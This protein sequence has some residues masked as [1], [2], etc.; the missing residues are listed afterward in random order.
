M[1]DVGRRARP[2][3]W[4]KSTI[5]SSAGN[6]RRR[7]MQVEQQHKMPACFVLFS[8]HCVWGIAQLVAVQY[9]G[10]TPEEEIQLE[11]LREDQSTRARLVDFPA[12]SWQVSRSSCFLP[13]PQNVGHGDED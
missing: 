13:S 5:S 10:V 6:K 12:V 4:L 2:C 8:G 1:F 7:Q 9:T 11:L 3:P